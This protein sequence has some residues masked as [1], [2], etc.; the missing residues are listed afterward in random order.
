MKP[1]DI[2]AVVLRYEEPGWT[3]QTLA[4]CA[5]AGITKIIVA[6]RD[7]VGN[8]SRALNGAL[9]CRGAFTTKYIWFLTN[10]TF[11]PD[12]PLALMAAFD[13]YT[14][15]VHPCHKSDHPHLQTC[16]E[17]PKEV[18]FVEFTA[19]MFRAL[20]LWLIE[21]ADEGMPY[22]G[23]DL[24]WSFRAKEAGYN[25]KVSP[26]RVEHTYLRNMAQKHPITK[27]RELMRK[28]WY[29]PTTQRLISKHG[30]DWAK[31]LWPG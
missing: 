14:A 19:P 3:E 28:H 2:T 25:L 1:T 22:W 9:F 17:T 16:G 24:D 11:T 5:A 29:N 21:G 13:P 26:A 23:M 12:T 31:K 15:A 30:P 8:M 7:G 27:I 10:V 20:H 6:E 4:C 18:P